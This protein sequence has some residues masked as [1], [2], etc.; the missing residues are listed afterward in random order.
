[1]LAPYHPGADRWT[2]PEFG[3]PFFERI[4]ADTRL[5]ILDRAG[6]LPVEEP[7]L[8]QLGQATGDFVRRHRQR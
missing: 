1:M 4:A 2:P 6:H 3:L 5:V 7:G 8:T